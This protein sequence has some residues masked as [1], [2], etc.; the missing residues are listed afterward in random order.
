MMMG[1]LVLEE[2]KNMI[3]ADSWGAVLCQF[4]AWHLV[5][6]D[7]PAVPIAWKTPPAARLVYRE[8]H[9]SEREKGPGTSF[10]NQPRSMWYDL[11]LFVKT[12]QLVSVK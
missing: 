4:L 9:G 6:G 5:L 7:R 11:D 2:Q 10:Q 8:A 12:T 3:Q 1:F